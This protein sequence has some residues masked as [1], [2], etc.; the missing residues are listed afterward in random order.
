[1]ISPISI[2][3]VN[4]H[5]ETQAHTTTISFPFSDFFATTPLSLYSLCFF[6]CTSTMCCLKFTLWFNVNPVCKIFFQ[7]FG[8]I[9]SEDEYMKIYQSEPL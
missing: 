6:F 5:Y 3:S 2:T 7:G 9:L 1:M 8:P 4:Q